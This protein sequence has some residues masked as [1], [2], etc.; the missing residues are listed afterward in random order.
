MS[1][2]FG[3]LLKVDQADL[4]WSSRKGNK[5]HALR[6]VSFSLDSG[7]SLAVVGESGSGKT[8]L[9]RTIL[10]LI[11]LDSGHIRLLG[12]E[13]DKCGPSTLIGLRR[14]CGF[15]PQDPYGCL[16]PTLKVLE[17]V[18]EPFLIARGKGKKDEAVAK[19]ETLLEE[20]G[21]GNGRIKA[22]HL[23]S[24]LSGG[25]RQRVSVARALI[26]EPKLLLAD[27]PT[28]MQDASTRGEIIEILKKRLSG[29]M[30]LVFVTHDL[31]LA[32]AAAEKTLVLYSGMVC[33][34][35]NSTAILK[36]PV[37]PYS[38]ALLAALP[39]LGGHIKVAGRKEGSIGPEGGC[40]FY[41]Q[42]PIADVKCRSM[43][44]LREIRGRMAAC[45]KISESD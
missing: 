20:L 8:T 18:T 34:Y 23:R 39:K 5:A 31:I 1:D 21:L 7:G 9:L 36:D 32:R 12:T 3:S 19:A 24:G 43:P 26:L 41:P 2:N 25:Q 6:K 45:W 27:E 22:S 30:S 38:K 10:G 42:C 29:G 4:T 35:G 13:L 16:P 40:P 28:S 33:E 15:I 11:P 44:P 17:A 14:Q 37:H